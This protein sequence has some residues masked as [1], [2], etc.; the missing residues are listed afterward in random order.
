MSS[1]AASPQSPGEFAAMLD[2]IFSEAASERRAAI[3]KM[4]DCLSTD[5]PVD[6][7]E[8][9]ALLATLTLPVLERLVHLFCDGASSTSSS[10][11][12]DAAERV[13]AVSF[14]CHLCSLQNEEDGR[15]FVFAHRVAEAGGIKAAVFNL[16]KGTTQGMDR[17]WSI[18]MVGS[19]SRCTVAVGVWNGV[20]DGAHSVAHL[21]S[22]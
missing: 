10:S 21:H 2:D 12:S 22:Y 14:L 18:R 1:V 15:D 7:P 9:V 11:S 6:D 17:Y 4:R 13:D 19:N 3:A 20:C 8:R 16:R 5:V